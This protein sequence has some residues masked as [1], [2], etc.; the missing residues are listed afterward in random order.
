[1]AWLC[2]S[3][4]AEAKRVQ[5]QPVNPV[6][7][8]G[9]KYTAPHDNGR[10]GSIVAWAQT[11][12]TKLWEQTVYTVNFKSKLEEDVQWVFIT[13][14]TVQG[15]SLVIQAEDR[16]VY[17]IELRTRQMALLNRQPAARTALAIF[18]A[19]EWSDAVQG[20]RGRLLFNEGARINQ[21][22]TGVIYLE[23]QNV[24]A[25]GTALEVYYHPLRAFERCE[26]SD[27][28]GQ[29]L[30]PPVNP[31]A[32]ITVPPPAWLSIPATFTLCHR[33]NQND[34]KP[35]LNAGLAI[36]I[37]GRFGKDFYWIIPAD[38]PAA[39]AL[40]VTFKS[41]VLPDHNRTNIWEGALKLPPVKFSLTQ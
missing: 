8:N 27:A 39:Y 35:H 11:T 9:I 40:S 41:V 23:L 13:S 26:L 38:A 10:A 17:S 12:G 15:D 25:T 31:F 6:I 16:Q 14:L 7:H 34:E 19:G 32:S 21:T 3:L 4:P 37:P 36:N 30:T 5:P 18:A 22:R 24:S 1:V 2:L 29:P 28:T 33:I 20:L